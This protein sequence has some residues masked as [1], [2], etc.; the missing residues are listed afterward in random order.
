MSDLAG[1]VD[2]VEPVEDYILDLCEATRADPALLLG[3]SPRASIAL[4]R[5]S[6]A[7]AAADG[8]ATVFPEDVKALLRPVL[9]HRLMLTADATLRGETIDGVIERV[10]AK[11]KPP[12]NFER[13][14]ITPQEWHGREAA[15]HRAR[16]DPAAASAV[17]KQARKGATRR[18]TTPL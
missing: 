16:R 11:V 13:A 17:K 5:A 3:A 15:M 1:E 14:P 18:R 8:R 7:L 9:S 10:V 12:L 6:R 4:V 2:I